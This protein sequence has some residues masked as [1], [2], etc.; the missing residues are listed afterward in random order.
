M[1]QEWSVSFGW[2]T[3]PANSITAYISSINLPQNYNSILFFAINL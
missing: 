2:Q 1:M 3:I